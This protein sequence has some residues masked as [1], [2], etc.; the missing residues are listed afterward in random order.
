MVA[1][2]LGVATYFALLRIAESKCET[3]VGGEAVPLDAQHRA[4][5]EA[6]ENLRSRIAAMGDAALSDRL[7]DLRGKHEI[8]VAPRLGPERWAVFVEALSLVRR[9]YIRREAL[10]DPVA[11]LYRTPRPD[12]PRPH[13]E[14]HAWIGLAGALR[15]ELAHRDGLRDEAQA[16]DAELAWYETVRYPPRLDAMPDEQRRAWEWGLEA[17]VL[18]ARKARAAAVGL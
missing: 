3:A 8:W 16:Y 15:H 1:A 13:Q 17:A 5:R 10:L 14:A 18:S 7:E 9:I 12:I 4:E 11:H 2:V 6:F